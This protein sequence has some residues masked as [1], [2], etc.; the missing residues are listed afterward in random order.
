MTSGLTLGVCATVTFLDLAPASGL[1]SPLQKKGGTILKTKC[2][3]LCTNASKRLLN[4][5][6]SIA[7]RTVSDKPLLHSLNDMKRA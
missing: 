5:R 6:V 3:G 7:C 2:G 4:G 1:P